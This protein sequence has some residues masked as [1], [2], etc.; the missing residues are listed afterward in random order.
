MYKWDQ[1]ELFMEIIK[2]RVFVKFLNEKVS[3]REDL[4]IEAKV[5]QKIYQACVL[6][7]ESKDQIALWNY[8]DME[9]YF[10]HSIRIH[11]AC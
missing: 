3:K 2:Q 10:E 5:M 9:T 8:N 11:K 1:A 6:L 7:Y 4:A